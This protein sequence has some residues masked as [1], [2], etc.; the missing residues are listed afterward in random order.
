[1]AGWGLL[2]GLGAGL[3][4]FGNAWTDKAKSELAQQLE[5][6]REER[7]EQRAIAKEERAADRLARTPAEHRIV[8]GEDGALW[9]QGFNASGSPV[10]DRQP[11]SADDIRSFNQGQQKVNDEARKRALDIGRL[12]Y[13]T[14]RRPV[15][16]ALADEAKRAQADS[17]R[18]SAAASRARATRS[19]DGSSSASSEDTGIYD[20]VDEFKK[21]VSSTLKEYEDVLPASEQDAFLRKV[22]EDSVR[23]GIQPRNLLGDAL[24]ERFGTRRSTP[25]KKTGQ[26]SLGN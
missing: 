1:M 5:L 14:Q 20:Y 10:G 17:Y 21:Q 19:L 15:E 7:A 23:Y 26:L 16:D 12:E 18:A 3:Q 25:G 22:L 4:Q 9:R 13:D 24:F 8:Q 2:S 6:Q 11:A